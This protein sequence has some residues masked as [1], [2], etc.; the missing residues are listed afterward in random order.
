MNES[1]T[2]CKE[3]LCVRF[4]VNE[5]KSR[6]VFSRDSESTFRLR[7]FIRG[8]QLRPRS[9]VTNS[10]LSLLNFRK[11]YSRLEWREARSLCLD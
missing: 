3:V 2:R 9:G 6:S 5:V 4:Q 11:V 10:K 7:L 1:I 8:D